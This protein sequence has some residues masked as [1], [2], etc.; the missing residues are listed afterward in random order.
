MPRPALLSESALKDALAARDQWSLSED[1]KKIRRTFEFAD[2]VQAFGFMAQCALE[3]EKLSHH[4]DWK[5][6]YNR[7]DVELWTH[8]AGG[9]TSLDFELAGRMDAFA[10]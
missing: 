3:A 2:F 7:I 9:L 6:V 1:G 8:D 10:S 4:P 5:N